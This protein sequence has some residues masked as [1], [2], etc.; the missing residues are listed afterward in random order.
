MKT[1]ALFLLLLPVCAF[2]LEVDEKLTV[3]LV[4][5]SES[6]KTLMVNRGTEDGLVEGA[7]A[8]FIVTAGIVARGVCV[9][10]SPS[11][12]VWSIYRLVNA[13]F[14]V[15]DSV[16]TIKITPAVKITKDE[17]QAIVEE[18]TPAVA[19]GEATTLGIPLAEG[20]QDIGPVGTDNLTDLK[21]LEDSNVPVLI[22]E[23]N[24]EVFGLLNISALSATTK[25]ETGAD[26]FTGSQSNHHI[27][28]G[29]ELY[30][31]KEREWYSRFSL[32]A[33]LNIMRQNNQAYNGSAST[34]DIT[35]FSLG[36]NWHPTKMPSQ[37]MSFI[38]FLHASFHLGSVESNYFTGSENPGG[39]DLTAAG[40]SAGFALGF[41][42]K[43]YTHRGFGVRALLDYYSRAEMYDKDAASNAFTKTVAGPRLMLGISYR[44]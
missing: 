6:R 5:I 28:L 33:A 4:K 40:K 42:Y 41:G 8:K 13:D 36:A 12:S 17:T 15:P 7:H 26:S 1:F 43:F 38:P 30:A 32:Q 37:T 2:S 14:V 24:K 19:A 35:E 11:R 44:F 34:N 22:A 31:Q 3:R 16:M 23:R 9:K 21:A 39:T 18:D 20:A 27:G 29:G 25:T 10:V